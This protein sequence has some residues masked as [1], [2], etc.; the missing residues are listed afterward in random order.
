LSQRVAGAAI[1][2]LGVALMVR[3]ERGRQIAAACF[4]PVYLFPAW[5]YEWANSMLGGWRFATE[6]ERSCGREQETVA[7]YAEPS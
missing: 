1:G 5:P 2:W 6:I 3:D 7:P 4:G